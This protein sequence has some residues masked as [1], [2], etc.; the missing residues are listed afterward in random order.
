MG[1]FLA[2]T[3]AYLKREIP[4]PALGRIVCRI[5]RPSAMIGSGAL[6]DAV[7]LDIFSG[8]LFVLEPCRHPP[9][10]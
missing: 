10:A 3:F 5:R 2:D 4:L 9:T 6:L 1:N 8:I 7:L